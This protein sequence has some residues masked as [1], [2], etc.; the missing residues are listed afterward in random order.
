MC[1][2]MTTPRLKLLLLLSVVVVNSSEDESPMTPNQI[3]L[4][5]PPLISQLSSRT[6]TF[7]I[8]PFNP[9]PKLLEDSSPTTLL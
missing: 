6:S 3:S 8:R 9:N 5:H 2:G 4:L 7:L 1:I